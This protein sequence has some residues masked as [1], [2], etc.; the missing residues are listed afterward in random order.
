LWGTHA[1]VGSIF[2]D[3][4]METPVLQKLLPEQRSVVEAPVV[5][6]ASDEILGQQNVISSEISD[7]QPV[8]TEPTQVP[9]EADKV[10]EVRALK[11]DEKC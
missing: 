7:M 10:V 11:L 4:P 8:N 6:T 3:A 9:R 1:F 5:T 2:C